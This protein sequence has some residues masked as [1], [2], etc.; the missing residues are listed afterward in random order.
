MIFVQLSKVATLLLLPIIIHARIP[1]TSTTWYQDDIDDNNLHD[2]TVLYDKD[3]KL[4]IT[5]SQSS[6]SHQQQFDINNP[7]ITA[8]ITIDSDNIIQTNNGISVDINDIMFSKNN[9]I[10]SED[11]WYSFQPLKSLDSKVVDGKLQNDEKRRY[12][13]HRILKQSIDNGIVIN[14]SRRLQSKEESLASSNDPF[15][16]SK[17][18]NPNSKETSDDESTKE[19]YIELLTN[20]LLSLICVT[21]AALA[22]GLTMGMLSLDV[23]IM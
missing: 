2:H 18:T 8:I 9:E 14:S 21:M 1:S 16:K 11:Y 23:S 7:T 12:K 3:I 4:Q 10:F 13:V 20:S 5:S 6:A 15:D 22:A 17:D 19:E